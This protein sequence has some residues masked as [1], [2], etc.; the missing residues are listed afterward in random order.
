MTAFKAALES[1][2]GIESDIR[3][4]RGKLVISHDIPYSNSI[5]FEELLA[6]YKKAN[7]DTFLAINIKEDDLQVLLKSSLDNFNIKNYFVFDMSVPDALGYLN[8]GMKV[9]TRESE[10]E[11]EPS[12]YEQADGV[13]LH[14]FR[15]PWITPQR[16]K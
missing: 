11:T 7:V 9:F 6:L 1:G 14:E 3:N 5:P 4:D 12:F 13:W 16:I 10:F 2:F 15:T 8:L